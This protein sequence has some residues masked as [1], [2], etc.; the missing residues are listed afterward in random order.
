MIESYCYYMVLWFWGKRKIMRKMGYNMGNMNERIQKISYKIENNFFLTVMRHG[1]TLMIPFILTGGVACALMNLPFIDYTVRIGNDNLIWLYRIFETVYQG[2]FGLFSLVLAIVLALCYGMERNETVDKVA[3]YIVVSLGAFGAQLNISSEAFDIGNLGAQGSFSAMFIVLLSCFAYEKL[4]KVTALTLRKYAVGMES[5]CANAIQA[6]LPMVLIIAMVVAFTRVLHLSFGVYNMH[7]LFSLFSCSLFDNIGNNFGA[8]L[9]YTFLLHLLWICGF[10]GSHL[11]EPVAQ[12]TFVTVS[13]EVVFSKSFFDT[14]VVMGGCGTTI[15]VLLILLIFYRKDRMS[16]LAKIGSFTVIF[17]LNEVLNFGLPIIL[18]PVMAIPF[19]L[20]PV[21]C[22]LVAYAATY[23]GLVPPLVQQIAW[24]TPP[25]FSG[26]MATGSVRGMILQLVCI[27]MGMAVYFPFIRM[28]KQIQ[29]IY[30]REKLKLIIKE[31]QEKEEQ[32]EAPKFLTRA[33]SL[34]LIS[35]MLLEDLKLA[36]ENDKLFMLYQPQVDEKGRCLGAEALL[37]WQHP[38]YGFIYPPLIIYLAKEGGLL[39]ALETRVFDMAS[40][41]V[42]RTSQ[43]YDGEFKIS[44]NITAKSLLWDIESCIESCLKKYDIPA[45]RLWVE[46]TEQDVITNADSVID[47]MERLK[48]CG[49]VLLIDDFGMG[50]TSLIYLQS[51]YFGVVKLDGSLVKK[52]LENKTNQKIVASIVE[53]GN[54]LGVKVIAEYVETEEQRD[55][56]RDLGCYWYQ[57]YLFS[58]PVDLDTFITFINEYNSERR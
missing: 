23:F 21:L 38:L 14:Y 42:K 55:M 34:G 19:I 11:L 2:T 5:L 18:N 32:N 58:K 26:Y 29:E 57:G 22:Y 15:C 39:P 53:L 10:H 17:N 1:L 13:D 48:N 44:V 43:E 49:H 46:I 9:L 36:I 50:H 41:A 47:K 6:L 7:E 27:A 54:E 45:E 25:L 24:S 33:D 28:H 8:G 20:T 4:K 52:I 51:N 12:T 3:L 16:N 56:L 30:A 35:R 37:R 31:L 40:A